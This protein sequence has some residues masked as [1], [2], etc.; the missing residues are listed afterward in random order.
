MAAGRNKLGL[1]RDE[2]AWVRWERCQMRVSVGLDLAIFSFQSRSLS[3]LAVIFSRTFFLDLDN[4]CVTI[5]GTIALRYCL[6]LGVVLLDI[7]FPIF[8]GI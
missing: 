2:C 1:G 7:T 8:F 6:K 5:T 3:N 4:E